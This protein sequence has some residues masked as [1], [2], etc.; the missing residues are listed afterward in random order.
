LLHNA[1]E[2]FSRASYDLSFSLILS[3][4]SPEFNISIQ[5]AVGTDIK[6]YIAAFYSYP[7]GLDAPRVKVA[8]FLDRI[9]QNA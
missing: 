6:V 2:Y 7:F 4:P 3:I 5:R 1:A 8:I 9:L